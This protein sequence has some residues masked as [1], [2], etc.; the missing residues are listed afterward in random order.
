MFLLFAEAGKLALEYTKN[1]INTPIPDRL[2]KSFLTT[3]QQY[4]DIE[5]HVEN[6]DHEKDVEFEPKTLMKGLKR[7]QSPQPSSKR[8]KYTETPSNKNSEFESLLAQLST[9]T[10]P[11]VYNSTSYYSQNSPSIENNTIKNNEVCNK[12]QLMCLNPDINAQ[13]KWIEDIMCLLNKLENS[14]MEHKSIDSPC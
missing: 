4:S 10:V 3:S 11:K 12:N 13:P 5:N 14:D 6:D 7:L 1:E 2:V 8:F 9:K